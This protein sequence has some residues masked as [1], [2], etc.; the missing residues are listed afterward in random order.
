[1]DDRLQG[2][3][4]VEK[5]LFPGFQM[6]RWLWLYV[7]FQALGGALRGSNNKDFSRWGSMLASPYFMKSNISPSL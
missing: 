2:K 1:M 7:A 4:A 5:L 3:N 6:V